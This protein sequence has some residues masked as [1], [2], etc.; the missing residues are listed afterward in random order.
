MKYSDIKKVFY[1]EQE[2]V[3]HIEEVMAGEVI[4]QEFNTRKE[5]EDYVK[6]IQNILANV[7]QL[8]I[9]R[10]KC[11]SFL[12]QCTRTKYFLSKETMVKTKV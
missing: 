11:R 12:F 10:P 1:H 3:Y 8:Q 9:E 5:A 7:K 6:Y 4:I 2:P